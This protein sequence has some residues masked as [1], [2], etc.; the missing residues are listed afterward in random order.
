MFRRIF[1]SAVIVSRC[2]KCM[3]TIDPGCIAVFTAAATARAGIGVVPGIDVVA[4]RDA[5]SG[6]TG[7]V[8]D[9]LGRHIG[10]GWP[11]P[12]PDRPD[13]RDQRLPAVDDLSSHLVPSEVQHRAV[14]VGVVAEFVAV[15]DEAMAEVGVG[16]D[17]RSD[18]KMR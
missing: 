16:G 1:G 2:P 14:M 4:D 17:P 7:L 10:S 12:T 6:P 11:E 8:E 15:V 13:E 9:Q 3:L 18:R 5:I